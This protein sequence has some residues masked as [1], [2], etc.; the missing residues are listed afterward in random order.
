M[1]PAEAS[2][3]ALARDQKRL[4]VLAAPLGFPQ[5]QQG[6][7]QGF[8]QSAD[9]GRVKEKASKSQREVDCQNRWEP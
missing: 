6:A 4:G 5:A 9:G 7:M 1:P 2:S 3:K 8:A